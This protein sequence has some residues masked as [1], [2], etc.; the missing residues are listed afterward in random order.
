MQSSIVLLGEAWG[1]NEERQRQAF[2]G[3]TGNL[4]NQLLASAGIDRRECFVTN[5][6]NLR[7]PGNNIEAFCGPKSS[8]IPNYPPLVVGKYVRREF[9][10]ELDRLANDIAETNP[11]IIVCF[12]NTPLWALSGKTGVSKYRGTTILSTYT[13]V[14]YKCLPTFHPSY[15]IRGQWNQRPIVIA[16]LIKAKRQSTSPEVVRP[17]REIWI[18]PTLEDLDDFR[19]KHIRVPGR[20]AVDIETSGDIITCL[21]LAPS[22][23][24]CLVVPFIDRRRKGNLYWPTQSDALHAWHFIR[25]LLVDRQ[26]SKTFQNG[27]FDITFIYRTTGIKTLN[28]E[29]DTM[30]LHHAL[31]PEMMKGLGFLGS[32]YTDEGAWKQ[33]RGRSSTI[34][35][36]E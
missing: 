31:Q 36:E 7:P 34:K 24:H 13:A 2:V 32:V 22:D 10:P 16:D 18:N 15:I 6:F 14:G 4:L 26:I 28:A 8:A 17:A 3:Y 19:T 33:L 25:S 20:L 30:L 29:H 5:V 12:G 11:N 1:E 21:G 27:L 35:R 9:T 23:R